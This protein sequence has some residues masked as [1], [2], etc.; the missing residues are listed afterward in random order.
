MNKR[1][2]N[3]V[4][5]PASLTIL[6]ILVACAA[7]QAQV[8]ANEAGSYEVDPVHSSMIFR[9]KHLGITN[10]YGRFNNLSGT[11]KIDDETPENSS[12]EMFVKTN[13]V[14]TFNARRDEHLRSADFFDAK[15]FSVISFKSESFR[16]VR[17][18][19]YEVT[20]DLHLH[21]VT[22]RLKVEA[23]YT[24]SGKDPSGKHR[25]GFETS[26]TV[27]RS[28]FGM[29]FMLGGVSDEVLAIVSVQG[30]RK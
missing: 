20:G 22:R 13:D 11:L 10:I 7:G 8:R 28:D 27:R 21:G 16:K 9:V 18:D 6:L 25:I 3:C 26:F 29:D 23:R 4:R 15:Q 12:V 1:L 24:G 17:G 2:A 30:I 5:I 14:D 19:M